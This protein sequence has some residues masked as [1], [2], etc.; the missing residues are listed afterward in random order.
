MLANAKAKQLYA[1]L[2]EVDLMHLLADDAAHWQ[3]MMAG[4]VLCYFGALHDVLA[5]AHARLQ[6]D[7]WLIF[8]VEELLPDYDGVVRGEGGWALQRQ[9]R[10]AH[11]MD[12]VAAVARDVGFT[13][14]TLERQTLRYEADA[15]VH[16][17]FAV[18]GHTQS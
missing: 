1:D 6:P 17:L 11:T 3:L 16:G 18:L 5:A 9:G 10:Y 13:I 15:P 4:D 7:G 8:T 14:R 12:Y 2:R